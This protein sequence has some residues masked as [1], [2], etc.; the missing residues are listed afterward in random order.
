M[1]S[2]LTVYTFFPDDLNSDLKNLADMLEDEETLME[3]LEGKKKQTSLDVTKSLP[4][5]EA[6]I[7]PIDQPQDLLSKFLNS[8]STSNPVDS[9]EL[10]YEN[11]NE[12]A[13]KEAQEKVMLEGKLSQLKLSNIDEEHENDENALANAVLH[14]GVAQHSCANEHIIIPHND[15]FDRQSVRSAAYSTASTFSPQEVKSRLMREHKKREIHEKMKVNPKNVKGD[16]N[17]LRRRKQN[18]QALA[19]EDMQGYMESFYG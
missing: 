10:Y 4:T 16:A 9:S 6:P 13:I 19:V 12:D 7:Q 17:A 15:Q 18:D 11:I 14:G 8:L 5:K 1:I 3:H 2:I